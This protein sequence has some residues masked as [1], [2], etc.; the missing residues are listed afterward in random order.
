MVDAAPRRT[1]VQ[2]PPPCDVTLGMTCVD[3]STPG[4]TV[5]TM[6]ADER[7]A[8][9][10]GAMQGGFVAAFVDSA[11]AATSVTA[12]RDRKVY[13]ANTDLRISFFKPVRGGSTLTCTAT[14]VSGGRRVTFVEAEVVGEAG[15]GVARA[16]STFLLTERG[17]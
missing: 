15:V 6:V 13:T 8:N 16:A 1:R 17:G 10:V 4:T 3:K 2:I 14:A 11:M 12:N 9:P 7:F 5:W